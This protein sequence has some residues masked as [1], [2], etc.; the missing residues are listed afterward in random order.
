M[1]VLVS[2]SHTRNRIGR[3]YRARNGDT[4]APLLQKGQ[5]TLCA[6]LVEGHFATKPSASGMGGSVVGS[7]S[8]KRENAPDWENMAY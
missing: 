5:S 1:F 3:V 2:I 8:S 6:F 4:L 7:M